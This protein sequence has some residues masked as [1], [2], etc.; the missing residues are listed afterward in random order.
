MGPLL[1][2]TRFIADRFSLQRFSEL[3]LYHY[4]E[5]RHYVRRWARSELCSRALNRVA[6]LGKSRLVTDSE[7]YER[8][9]LTARS[10][11]RRVAQDGDLTQRTLSRNIAWRCRTGHLPPAPFLGGTPHSPSDGSGVQAGSR[12]P[13]PSDSRKHISTRFQAE[14]KV[15]QIM[16]CTWALAM[17]GLP[18]DER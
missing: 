3:L 15:A 9:V 8:L 14:I 13:T 1:T 6:S 17:R 7:S 4:K 11:S 12:S 16:I 2:H 10:E 5:R 18:R